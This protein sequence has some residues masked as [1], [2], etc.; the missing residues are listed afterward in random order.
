MI[1]LLQPRWARFSSS[2]LR[3]WF[4]GRH[5]VEP[6][7]TFIRRRERQEMFAPKGSVLL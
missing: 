7:L 6:R 4:L 3:V 5:G 2:Y 1:N